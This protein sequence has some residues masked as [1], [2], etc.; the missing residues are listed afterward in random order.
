[1]RVPL[2]MIVET[3]GTIGSVEQGGLSH[4]MYRYRKRFSVGWPASCDYDH[5][6]VEL[7]SWPVAVAQCVSFDPPVQPLL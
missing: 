1:M 6:A 2:A 5:H 7:G 4:T 3:S